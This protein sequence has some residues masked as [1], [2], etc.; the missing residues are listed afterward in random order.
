MELLG[1]KIDKNI[2]V[3]SILTIGS[4]IVAAAIAY[5]SN[6][7]KMETVTVEQV[8][9]AKRIKVNEDNI[10]NLKIGVAKLETQLD[11]RF[12][13]LEDILMDLE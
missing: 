7:Y 10:V 12:D 13:R 1:V 9:T 4:I 5:G 11:D 3:G 8:K 2:S 6:T